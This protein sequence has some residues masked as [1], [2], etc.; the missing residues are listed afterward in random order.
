MAQPVGPR[1]PGAGLAGFVR[2]GTLRFK[3]LLVVVVVVLAPVVWV[4]GSS[5]LDGASR[6]GMRRDLA[7]TAALSARAVRA[8][9]L[10]A[11]VVARSNRVRIRVVDDAGTVR[12]DADHEGRRR[13]T[14]GFTDVFFGPEGRPDPT[15]WDARRPSLLE[16]PEVAE[17]LASGR[18]QLCEVPAGS[19][20]LVCAVAQRV[21][22]PDGPVLLH[23]QS[24][25]ARSTR[26]LYAD[27]FQ[28]LQL[29]LYMLAFAVVI[30]VWL[31]ARWIRPLESLRDEA[32]ARTQGRVSTAP[33]EVTS[34]DELGELAHAFNTLLAAI[35]SRNRANEVFAADLAHELKNPIAAV[36]TAAEALEPGKPLTEARAARLHRIL[37]DSSERMAVVIDRFLELARAEAG[38]A[39]R[40]RA[41]LDLLGLAT[42]V[43]DG[44][45]HDERFT[46]VTFEVHGEPAVVVG[47]E[48]RLETTLRNLVSN[49]ACFAAPDGRVTVTTTL[50]PGI[51]ELSVADTGPGIA[52]DDLPRVFDRYFTRRQGGTGLG[53]ALSRAIAHA[54]G[55]DLVAHSAPGEGA[56]FTLTLPR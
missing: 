28:M 10:Q 5:L 19:D 6:I 56:V 36:R 13:W 52:P 38:L 33:L 53:L 12:V 48:E 24:S 49:A 44:A 34:K 22:G 35:E 20:L 54:H 15:A 29:T 17:A 16:R 9:T 30:T 50:R 3:A 23:V 32:L 43:V 47:S 4:W 1:P 46:G 27:R 14:D 40:E 31:G 55:G 42:A 41:S 45:R 21:E 18:G 25:L 26:A 8:G 2:P 11:E 39:D 51:V 37:A 7:A